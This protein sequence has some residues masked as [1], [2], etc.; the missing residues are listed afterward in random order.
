[1]QRVGGQG[2]H[3][4][5][6][7]TRLGFRTLGARIELCSSDIFVDCGSG[8][9]R[10]VLQAARE[11]GVKRA[12][13]IECSRSRHQIAFEASGAARENLRTRSTFICADCADHQLWTIGGALADATVVFTCS[14]MF[15]DALMS[16]LAR[17][18]EESPTV[19]V[20]ATLKRFPTSTEIETVTEAEEK[21]PHGLRGFREVLPPET[22]E[23]SW[24][25]PRSVDHP[26]A[27]ISPGSNV[28]IYVRYKRGDGYRRTVGDGSRISSTQREEDA[29]LSVERGRRVENKERLPTQDASTAPLALPESDNRIDASGLLQLRKGSSE[30]VFCH[31]LYYVYSFGAYGVVKW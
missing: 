2:A 27:A 24:M 29:D 20:V 22:C 12:I 18:I 14:V 3:N 10:V 5:G 6:D 8:T 16:R 7:I 21:W 28:Y 11:Y 25:A 9:G 19:R 17:C 23:T 4:Y 30:W 31:Q 15:S 26:M 1:M 13:G